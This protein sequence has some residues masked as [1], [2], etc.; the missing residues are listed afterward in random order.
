MSWRSKTYEEVPALSVRRANLRRSLRVVTVATLFGALWI[1]CISGAHAK[2]FFRMLGLN[3]FA[4]GIMAALPFVATFNQIVATILIERTGLTKYQFVH[5]ATIFRAIWLVIALV[6]LFLP[7]PSTTAV[8]MV[9]LLFGFGHFIAAIAMP[10]RMTWMGDLIPRRI[11]GRNIAYRARLAMLVHISVA[12][13]LG[14]LIDAV[15]RD[16]LPETAEAQPVLLWTI[17]GIIAVSAVFG[18]TDILLFRRIRQVLPSKKFG[19]EPPVID[20]RVRRPAR[21]TLLSEVTFPFAYVKEAFKQ[22]IIYPLKDR[23]FRNYVVYGA[24]ITFTATV[25]AWFFWFQALET[26]EFSKLGA[27]IC[28]LVISPL[29]AIV[30][31]KGWGKLVD[32]WGSK[33]TLIL[34]TSGTL[35]S[36]MPW[37][38]A[39]RHTPVPQFVIDGTNW[40]SMKLGWLFGV[41][42]YH[43][44]T[45]ATP[46]GA[47]LLI[48]LALLIGGFCWVGINIAQT[49]II[50]GFADG[51]GRSKYIAASAVLISLGGVLGGLVGG[52]VAWSLEFLQ[53]APIGPFLWTNWH[54]TFALSALSRFVGFIWL[55]RMPAPG[56]RRVRDLLRST[57]SNVYNAVATR[58]LYQVRIF[59]WGRP[60]SNNNKNNKRRDTK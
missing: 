14:I 55:L 38:F 58:L 5:C 19:T 51:P 37:F 60:K 52:L 10:A 16:D 24:S 3:D 50:M 31:I 20:I 41:E 13:A 53:D 33:P 28:F 39:T 4:F 8:V 9:L 32:K 12:I 2:I 49:N 30:S 29:A 6:P 56:T 45:D 42:N 15:V 1:A 22:V 26:L 57:S 59:G 11:R 7:I 44:I 35:L 43:I 48:G 17:C 54:A 40:V 23:V 47:Y 27:N 25:G 34:G 36:I 21:R 18:V 46:A